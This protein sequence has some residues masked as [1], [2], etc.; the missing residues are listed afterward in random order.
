MSKEKYD[1]V[2]A[3]IRN[4]HDQRTNEEKPFPEYQDIID[5]REDV[6][7]RFQ[8]EFL[9]VENISEATFRDFL[10]FSNNKHWTGLQRPTSK[11][12]NDMPRLRN[13]LS[14]LFDESIG[15]SKRIDALTNG[16]EHDV[17]GLSTGIL[18]PLLLVRFP[19]K[20]GVWNGKS[21]SA[22]KALKVWPSFERGS[23][24]G[25]KYETLNN[26]FLQIAEKSA[27]DLWCLDGI[28]HVINE[29][30]KS[31]TRLAFLE[32]EEE[33]K[34]YLEGRRSKYT[35]VRVERNAVAR[36]QCLKTKGYDCVVC[37]FNFFEFYGELGI[38]YI[39]VHHVTDL[40]LSESERSVNPAK[41]L[42]PVCP[43]CHAMLHKGAMP[44]RSVE[45]LKKMI[46][47]N[48]S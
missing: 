4:L 30:S 10:S 38:G 46:K 3:V 24:R 44:A 28:W 1:R 26:V 17:P 32:M 29:K 34:A 36:E 25:K 19:N 7:A 23:S 48:R 40:A 9:D 21:E 33:E 6:L 45:N 37:G 16:G 11:S 47:D 41:D 43:N 5:A 20:Y 13:A 12:T 27:L 8:P 15:I 42:V 14:Y 39:H 22:T 35:G 31:D 18:T 2:A